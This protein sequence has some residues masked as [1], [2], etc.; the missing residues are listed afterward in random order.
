[1]TSALDRLRADDAVTELTPDNL[2][3]LGTLPTLIVFTGDPARKPEVHDIAVVT[4][5][6]L[7]VHRGALRGAVVGLEHDQAVRALLGVN[8]VPAVA[9]ARGGQ[10]EEL[11]GGIQ[12]W[13]RYEEALARLLGKEARA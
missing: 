13:V 3:T 9:F 10:V 8:K 11:L 7:R 4:R 12:D 2:D 6:M 1:M 5:E